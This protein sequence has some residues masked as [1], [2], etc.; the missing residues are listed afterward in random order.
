MENSVQLTEKHE[1]EKENI[2]EEEKE[3]MK[4][5]NLEGKKNGKGKQ[6]ED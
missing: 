1:T 5:F 4:L 3:A 6:K 2:D